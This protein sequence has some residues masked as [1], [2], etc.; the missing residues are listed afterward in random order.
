M[1]VACGLLFFLV[2]TVGSVP[3]SVVRNVTVYSNTVGKPAFVCRLKATIEIA[4]SATPNKFVLSFRA[5]NGG[6]GPI[7]LKSTDGE[8]FKILRF[9][10]TRNAISADIDPEKEALEFVLQPKVDMT[11]FADKMLGGIID[12]TLSHPKA[13][14]VKVSYTIKPLWVSTPAKF[15][16]MGA[17]RGTVTQRSL[18]IKSNYGEKVEIES[19]TSQNELI[20]VI[21][22]KQDGNSV[23]MLV[24]IKTPSEKEKPQR[25]IKDTLKIK[26]KTGDTLDI[27][28]VLYLSK[29]SANK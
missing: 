15:L 29:K 4:V 3:G 11:K 14:S 25:F 21:S 19:V 13:K 27:D 17:K 7:K 6:I 28:C 22:Q 24:D 12:I 9:S 5:E 16:I 18:F 10:S 1:G 26:L 8:A 2:Y 20:K 23:R